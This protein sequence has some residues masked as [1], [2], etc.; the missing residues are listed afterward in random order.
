MV[1]PSHSAEIESQ[2]PEVAKRREVR[3]EYSQEFPLI[4]QRLKVSLLVS[5]YQAGKLAVVGV[6]DGQVRFAFHNFERVMGV[7]ASPRRIA[8]GARRQ[9]YFLDAAHQLA[10]NVEPRGTYDSCW[11]TRSAQ[12]TGN[13]HGHELG[14]GSEGLWVINTL[15]SSLC[16]MHEDYSF[17]PRWRP[18]FISEMAAQDRCHLNGLA[19]RDGRPRFATAHAETDTPA[20]WRPDKATSG[21]VIDIDANRVLLHGLC[22]P[23]SP[24]WH[25]G[26]LW[27][28]DSG[29][30]R[31]LRIDPASAAVEPVEALPGYARGMALH[32]RFAFI[33]LS[34]IRETAVFGGVPLAE[35]RDELRCG[36]AVVDLAQGKAVA[37]LQFHSGVDE[38]FAVEVLPGCCN[39]VLCGPAGDDDGRPD[40]WL[41]PPEN[42]IPKGRAASGD[43]WRSEEPAPPDGATLMAEGLRLHKEGRLAESLQRLSRAS[44]LDGT[45]PDIQNHLG[46]VRQD[47]GDQAGA[48]ECYR[49]AVQINPDYAPAQQNLGYL[50]AS[51]GEPEEG[52]RHFE[53]AQRAAPQPM[54]RA[55]AATVLP[56]VYDSP[57]A[58]DRWR[59]RLCQQV[60]SLVDDGVT[61]DTTDTLVPT[62]FFFAYQG[63]NDRQLMQNLGRVYRGVECCPPAAGSGW[64]PRGPRIQVGFLSGYFRDH[65]IG[66]LNL[67]RIRRLSREKF[68]VTVISAANPRQ[69]GGDAFQQ[70]A[71][72]FV[73]VPRQVATARRQIAE[74]GLDILFFADVG[75]DAL[76]QTL[77]YSRMA[78]IQC[79]TWGHPDTTG[80]PAIDYFVSSELLETPEAEG[81]YS[82]RLA[83]LPNLGTYYQRPSRPERSRPRETWGLALKSHVY[84]CPQTLFKF[85]P[86]FDE[87]L[88]AILRTDPHGELVLLEGRVA[89][90]TERLRRRLSGAL[91]DAVSRVRFLPAQPH[92]DFMELLATADVILDPFPF[93]GGN[94]SYEA[95]AVD[96]P[97][98]T[99]PSPYL[100]GRITAALYAK[101]GW[102]ACI[103]QSAEQ[104]AAVATRLAGD[105]A[106]QRSIR[107]QIRAAS[108]VLFEDIDEVRALEAFFCAAVD[109]V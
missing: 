25:Q 99:W 59:Q 8:V 93:G 90:W 2:D 102:S 85:H 36:V 44:E 72:R 19:M 39:P 94:T 41:V 28:L 34:K 82:E 92:G 104:Y 16:T 37:W 57:G 83:R 18:P 89:N 101:M 96:T 23:H 86:R 87:V 7:A 35:H 74:L 32:Q 3:F 97:V 61:I 13:I 69:E 84:L 4:L 62:S 10:A 76:T 64:R 50:M 53:L 98:V 17:V 68:A 42:R 66:R 107:K 109:G 1:E 58:V 80:S 48:V 38:I 71:D 77:S 67:E 47:V 78:P 79:V 95:L 9:I 31:L 12:V 106:Y 6:H 15:F 75:M 49:R 55:L 21:C 105:G 81:H 27:V 91:G 33:G 56:V 46:N 22:M 30:G 63:E 43:P 51:W 11:L 14:W 103:V 60:Q 45:S 54:N 5:T 108:G 100:R 20:G 26:R 52:L 29:T 88:A 65:T 70:A 24:R 40:I 73:R